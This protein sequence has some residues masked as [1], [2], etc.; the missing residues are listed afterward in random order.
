MELVVPD[1]Y[2]DLYWWAESDKPPYQFYCYSGGRASGKSTTVAQSLVIR[3][4][5][6]QILVLCARE[7]QV[8][9]ADSVHALLAS[10]IENLEIPG[11]TVTK[12]NIRHQNGSLF[13]FKG[14]H[15]NLDNVKSTE[16][17]D[18]CWVEEAQS[19]S[20]KSIDILEPTIRKE[21]SVIIYTWNPKLES[22][23]V[24]VEYVA[25]TAPERKRL[26]LHK[27]TT[28]RDVAQ[29]LGST[30][31]EKIESKRGEPDFGHVY[32]GLPETQTVN[33]V[34][35]MQTL[36]DCLTVEASPG[37]HVLGVDVARSG[38]DRTAAC[39]KRGNVVEQ[40]Y[41]WQNASIVESAN[42]VTRLVEDLEV[43]LVRVDDTG[44]GGGLTDVLRD[45]LGVQRVQPI[46]FSGRARKP[47]KYP[48]VAS[49]L[50]FDFAEQANTIRINPEIRFRAELFAELSTRRWELDS[51]DRRRVESKKNWRQGEHAGSPDLA[52]AFLLACYPVKEVPDYDAISVA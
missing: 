38:G 41:A 46:V 1:V 5:R 24:W 2:R 25:V 15:N 4:A 12:N 13:I 17:V 29:L 33:Q 50:W 10:Q 3:A 39:F 31:M 49:E 6:E 19:I 35:T 9:I 20:K 47:R 48:N 22:D 36:M 23:P 44:L 16:G 30:M 8:S 7:F 51:R 11:F 18:V 32:E 27:H 40:L 34:I 43:D 45:R 52:D 26:V 42:E 28:Y 21:N 37:L 14:L